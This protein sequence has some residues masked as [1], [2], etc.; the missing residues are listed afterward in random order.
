MAGGSRQSIR[1]NFLHATYGPS[2]FPPWQRAKFNFRVR[3]H[4][5]RRCGRDS[6]AYDDA[7]MRNHGPPNACIR[8]YHRLAISE[9]SS[10]LHDCGFNIAG[11]NELSLQLAPDPSSGVCFVRKYPR[12]VRRIDVCILTRLLTSSLRACCVLVDGVA[13]R[14]HNPIH[15][16]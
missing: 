6:T 11:W 16:K 3:T 10:A 1:W 13:C 9:Q 7:T 2:F 8:L 12:M 5:T 4:S 15:R 14:E